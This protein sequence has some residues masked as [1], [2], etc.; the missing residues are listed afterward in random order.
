MNA[1]Y[2]HCCEPWVTTGICTYSDIEETCSISRRE[3]E[4]VSAVFNVYPASKIGTLSRMA[5]KL[6]RLTSDEK[7]EAKRDG[8]WVTGRMESFEED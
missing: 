7:K 4:E 2:C 1:A 6:I 5:T 8:Q 3:D